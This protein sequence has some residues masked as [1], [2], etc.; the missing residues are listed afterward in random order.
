MFCVECGKEG[1]IYKKGLCTACYIKE[2]S[3]T[4][5]PL[6]ISLIQCSKCGAFK[7][8]NTWTN[9]PLDNVILRNIKDVFKIAP[10]LSNITFQLTCDPIENQF[11]CD[12][13]IS[14]NLPGHIIKES[15]HIQVR[16]TR[17]VCD[18]CSKQYGGYYEAILQIRATDRK[19]AS[20]ELHKMQEI[21]EH[22]VAN[23][24][25]QGNRKLFITD[26]AEEHGGLDFYLSERGSAYNLARKLQ[27]IYG[28]ELKQS[29]SMVGMKEGREL[30]RVTVLLR[31]PGY[32]TG[33]FMKIEPDYFLIGKMSGSKIY[34]LNLASWGETTI[35]SKD[36]KKFHI[37]SSKDYGEEMI[38]ISQTP[39]ELQIMHQKSY[40][41]YEIVKPKKYPISSKTVT[42]VRLDDTL[43]LVPNKKE[44]R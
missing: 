1:P 38:V 17:I 41:N 32:Q 7:Y 37:Y 39:T 44:K 20:E 40:K 6:I 9:D 18:V 23:E 29:T 28:G 36:L 43:F 8:K 12:L 3:F 4:Q 2:T 33:D 26:I 13:T 16:I 42:V 15:H 31:L 19:L 24:H 27:K 21:I 22:S 25:I 14:G 11:L 5:G 10:E 30:T 35:D 34:L